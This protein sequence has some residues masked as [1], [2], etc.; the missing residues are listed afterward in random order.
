MKIVIS[1]LFIILSA[2][3]SSH[4]FLFT[5]SRIFLNQPFWQASNFN[6][7]ES[8]KQELIQLENGVLNE[9]IASH[10]PVLWW[11]PAEK[12]KSTD[13]SIVF[14]NSEIWFK[15]LSGALPLI[16][17]NFIRVADVKNSDW[18][19]LKIENYKPT[20]VVT[21]LHE[22]SG[23]KNGYAGFELKY[24]INLSQPENPPLLWRLSKHPI[25]EKIQTQNNNELFL[26][27]EIWYF[28]TYNYTDI[29]FGFHDGDWESALILFKVS[30]Q[31]SGQNSALEFSPWLI[32]LSAHGN[33]VWHCPNDFNYLEKRFEVFS[34]LGTHATYKDEGTQWRIYPDRTAKGTK[35][36]TWKNTRSLYQEHYYGFSGSWGRTSYIDFQNGPIPPGPDFKYL[37]RET[38]LE[39]AYFQLKQASEKCLR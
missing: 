23:L 34:A 21:R 29:H 13:P 30:E 36:E 20:D 1:G 27:L 11:H 7:S 17:K 24:D 32:S 9:K 18:R 25:F 14:E 26:P 37:P 22:L 38:N 6:K 31:I 8:I 35:W 19:N 4:Y 15:E 12:F 16:S 2:L 33:T 39:K 28:S 3:G 5:P 10:L